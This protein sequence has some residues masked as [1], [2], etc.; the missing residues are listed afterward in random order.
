MK[1]SDTVEDP[2]PPKLR[3]AD[4][5]FVER[6]GGELRVSGEVMLHP[7]YDLMGAHSRDPE[8]PHI[9]FSTCRDEQELIHFVG[10]FGPVIARRANW[11]NAHPEDPAA[12]WTSATP[13]FIYEAVQLL[14]ELREE[15]ALFQAAVEL[16]RLLRTDP[17][18]KR[19]SGRS[20][21][22]TKGGRPPESGGADDMVTLTS[23]VDA[24]GRIVIGTSKWEAQYRRRI[25]TLPGW[26]E[27]IREWTWSSQRQLRLEGHL[28]GGQFWLHKVKKDGKAPTLLRDPIQLGKEV[29]TILLNAFPPSLSWFGDQIIEATPD[30]L[31]FGVRPV[32]FAML[33][34]DILHKREIRICAR[35]GCGKYFTATRLDRRFCDIVCSKKHAS[36]EHYKNIVKPSRR[37]EAERGK[38]RKKKASGG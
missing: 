29:I 9:Q 32:L 17:S 4:K 35:S 11:K 10:Q 7:Q 33:R 34:R 20:K 23:I 18:Q 22:I 25:K 13:N 37:R 24:I 19:R 14:D 36:A 12:R 26:E 6:R 38:A 27:E 1:I 31:L 21:R 8:S 28:Y 16:S 3:W 2:Y 15:Q 30:D 5:V